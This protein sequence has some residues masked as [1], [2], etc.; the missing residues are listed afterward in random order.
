MYLSSRQRFCAK[1]TAAA[2][3]IAP[4]ANTPMVH[5]LINQQIFALK[6]KE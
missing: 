6:K 3:D 2:V 4:K 1:E 5:G